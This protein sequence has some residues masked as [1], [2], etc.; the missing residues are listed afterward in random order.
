MKTSQ[1]DHFKRLIAIF[2]FKNKKNKNQVE[3]IPLSKLKKNF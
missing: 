3:W 1:I 2:D